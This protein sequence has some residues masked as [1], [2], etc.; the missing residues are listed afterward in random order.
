MAN[1]YLRSRDII[2][3]LRIIFNIRKMYSIKELQ[4]IINQSIENEKIGGEPRGL[5]EP[6]EYTLQSGGKRIRPALVL[7]ACNLFTDHIDE[8]IRPA[9]GLEIFHNFTLLHD[10]IMDHA[11]IRR[12]L[13][14]VHKKWDENTAILSGDAMFIKAYEYFLDCKS[15]AFRDILK[16]F[17]QTAL[18]VCEGQQYDMEFEKRQ[19]VSEQEYIRMIELKT[20]VLL[21]AAL[22]IGAL[23]GGAEKPEADLLYEFGRNIGLA[24]QLQDDLLD[25]YGDENVFG[26]QIG[27]DI[28]SNKKTFLL[29]KAKEL[30]NNEKREIL[31]SW[32]QNKEADRI[33][34]VKA[35]TSIYNKIKIK[36]T[37]Q[38]RI[39]ELTQKALDYLDQINVENEKKIELKNLAGKL[40]NRNS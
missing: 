25:V 6:I 23:I 27:G 8:A 28:V 2:L 15:P 34:K 38:N 3:I 17:N 14:T 7:M 10:D 21:A 13:A 18:E 16:V 29:I 20:S 9:I 1:I 36:E 19:E 32:L 31:E 22:K 12:G 40:I 5:Y 11:D 35:V 33:E 37:T 4:D 24:F 30:A 26:K 39:L